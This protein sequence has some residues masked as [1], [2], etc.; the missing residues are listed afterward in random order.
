LI[1]SK[2][3]LLIASPIYLRTA[4]Q[5]IPTQAFLVATVS[6]LTAQP[7]P[8]PMHA[9]VATRADSLVV[10]AMDLTAAP[11]ETPAGTA[12]QLATAAMLLTVVTVRPAV[13]VT[14]DARGAS[15]SVVTVA[16]ASMAVAVHTKPLAVAKVAT[17]DCCAATADPVEWVRMH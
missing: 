13:V 12:E 4:P 7:A 10:V 1:A 3:L 6:V 8:A 2:R 5:V 16:M 9:T 15:E 14:V 11:E 17:A